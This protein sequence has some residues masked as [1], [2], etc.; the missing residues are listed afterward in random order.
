MGA[1]SP[2]DKWLS[3]AR[4]HPEMEGGREGAIAMAVRAEGGSAWRPDRVRARLT[5]PSC[6][7]RARARAS[8][9]GSLTGRGDERGDEEGRPRAVS[10]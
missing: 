8:S 3:E 9:E 6:A 7:G 5:S 1:K 4:W 2:L 10:R